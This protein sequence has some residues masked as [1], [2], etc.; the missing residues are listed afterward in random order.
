MTEEEQEK[1]ME[2]LRQAVQI[3][4]KFGPLIVEEADHLGGTAATAAAIMLSAFCA[5]MDMTMHDAV[6]L[7]MSVHKHTMAMER[8]V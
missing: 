6:G 8:D 4:N 5:E 1:A 7:L 2:V 3:A